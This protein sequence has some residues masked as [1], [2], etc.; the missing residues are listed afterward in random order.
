MQKLKNKTHALL[1]LANSTAITSHQL[2]M[3]NQTKKSKHSLLYSA[4]KQILPEQKK[5]NSFKL[6]TNKIEIP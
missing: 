5:L 2:L 1:A 3:K 6:S 4:S